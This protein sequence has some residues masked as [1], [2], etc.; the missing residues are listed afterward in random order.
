M[1]NMH[2]SIADAAALDQNPNDAY[3]CKSQA[4]INL[5]KTRTDG[6]TFCCGWLGDNCCTEKVYNDQAENAE[7]LKSGIKKAAG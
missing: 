4:N 2:V 7:D 1:C 5:C 3:K 6:K